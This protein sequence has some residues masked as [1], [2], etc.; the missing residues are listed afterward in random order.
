MNW[1]KGRGKL[2]IFDPLIGSWVVETDSDMGPVR[3]T[4]VF[5]KSLGGKYIELRAEWT[6]KNSR[7]QELALFGVDKDKKL[8]FWSFTSDGKN[9]KGELAEAT[10]IH[11]QALGFEA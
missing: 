7:Y 5:T 9:S 11:P 4:R 8:K 3:V 1:K 10:D 2:G 6:F